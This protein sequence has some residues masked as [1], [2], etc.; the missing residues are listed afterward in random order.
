MLEKIMDALSLA[1]RQKESVYAV[2]KAFSSMFESGG[3]FFKK[4]IAVFV[5]FI[6]MFGSVL[7][8]TGITPRGQQLDLTGYNLV[9]CD[10][11]EGD[12]LDTDIWEYRA[13]GSRRYGYNAPSQ[14][15]VK[16]GNLNIRGEYL[17]D[18][19]Y[20]PG[21]YVGMINLKQYYCRGYFE[22]RC[23][24]NKG[25]DFWS[26]FW[27]QA[28]HPYDHDISNGGIGGAEIDIF[29]SCSSGIPKSAGCVIS[30]VHCNGYD[31][32]V[33]NIDSRN[34]GKFKGQNIYDE[35]NTYGLEWNEEE[36]IFYINGVE[37]GR[38][39]WASGV[40]EVPEMLIVSLEIPDKVSYAEDSGHTTDFIVDYVKIYQKSDDM[41]NTAINENTPL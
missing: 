12:T 17:E 35:Y 32:D 25:N 15:S 22:I 30:T 28:D 2:G 29:E 11:F 26:A 31:D 9:F 3:D 34:I 4:I 39:S 24:C 10:E 36:Y 5:A 14:V 20:G 23:I 27:F 8:D 18:G 33:E 6:E 7:F 19:E 40:S 1:Y 38:T 21:W 37:T 13:S 16:D 41:G